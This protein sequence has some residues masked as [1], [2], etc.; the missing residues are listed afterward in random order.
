MAPAIFYMMLAALVIRLI[1]VVFVYPYWLNPQRDFYEFGYEPGRVARSIALGQ[2]ISNPLH[3]ITGPTA[4]VMP[5]Y[6]AIL[7]V[8]FKLFGIYSKGA[9]IGILAFNSL[10]S[11]LTCIPVYAIAR[12]TFNSRSA[13]IA[14]WIWALFPNAIYFSADWMWATC[15]ATLFLATSFLAALTLPDRDSTSLAP[16]CGF[17]AGCG[18]AALTEPNVM[19][20]LP[21]LGL[22]AC[23]HLASRAASQSRPPKRPYIKG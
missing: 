13:M 23:F 3:G 20:V 7:A 22:W 17:G 5:V 10:V 15:L 11:A 16:W 21:F 6:P 9:A 12:R 1:V 14:G 8:F 18:L 19:S 4:L 2:G